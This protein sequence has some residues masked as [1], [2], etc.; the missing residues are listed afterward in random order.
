MLTMQ[1]KMKIICTYQF[2]SRGL[3]AGLVWV[4]VCGWCA[5]SRPGTILEMRAGV[6]L[7]VLRRLGQWTFEKVLKQFLEGD[8]ML[9]FVDESDKLDHGGA[10]DVRDIVFDDIEEYLVKILGKQVP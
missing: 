1:Q 10:P 3:P 2:W 9:V 6:G 4:V 7:I 5:G 8:D